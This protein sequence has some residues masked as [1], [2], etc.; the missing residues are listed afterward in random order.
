MWFM[1]DDQVAEIVEQVALAAMKQHRDE[2]LRRWPEL[3]WTLQVHA[4]TSIRTW[5][6]SGFMRKAP[7]DDDEV[8][9]SIELQTSNGASE[10]GVYGW[11]GQTVIW[12]SRMSPHLTQDSAR[13][14]LGCVVGPMLDLLDQA[15][16]QLT[17]AAIA[18]R[19]DTR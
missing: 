3:H 18:A 19:D 12:E 6:I 2:L 14:F 10:L 7:V 16:Y 1:T 8:V 9:A 5:T 4:N 17:S 11:L 13:L 15:S